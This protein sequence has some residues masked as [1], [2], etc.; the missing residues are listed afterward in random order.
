MANYFLIFIYSIFSLFFGLFFDEG[1]TVNQKLPERIKPGDE[2]ISEITVKK[3]N[4]SGFAKLQ[5]EIPEGFKAKAIDTKGGNFSFN[6][7]TAKIIWTALP[8]ENEM[9]IKIAIESSTTSLGRASISG[10]FSFIQNNTKQQVDFG[11]NTIE[12]GEN[13]ISQTKPNEIQSQNNNVSNTT[14]GES[15][16]TANNGFE[17]EVQV[18]CKRK[19]V[20]FENGDFEVQFEIKKEGIKGFAKLLDRIP[21]GFQCAGVQT[22]G[23]SFSCFENTAKFV[24]VA[25]PSTDIL[26]VS[27]RL[28]P[29]DQAST[30]TSGELE[31]EFSYL[32]NEQTIQL[33]IPREALPIKSRSEE[34]LISK[35]DKPDNNPSENNGTEVA[36]EVMKEATTKTENNISQSQADSQPKNENSATPTTQSENSSALVENQTMEKKSIPLVSDNKNSDLNFCVQ[37][38]AF[39]NTINTSELSRKYSISD[40]IRSDQHEGYTKCL[41]GSFKEYKSAKEK[42]ERMKEK[43]VNDAFIAAYNSGKRITVQEALMISNQTWLK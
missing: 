38:G 21:N 7:K 11:P 17:K 16:T 2:F 28:I 15:T 1:V 6:E 33:L 34:N 3:E 35:N 32:Q 10:K 37:I 25:L 8:S 36:K 5:I 43:G 18:A 30:V 42:R 29:A 20:P 24:W 26:N 39:K 12:I 31:G 40:K 41:I 22:G 27:Y 23:G 13:S 14:Q 4:I 19:I 9:V